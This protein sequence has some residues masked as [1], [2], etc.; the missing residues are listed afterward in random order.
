[1]NTAKHPKAPTR[2][3][4]VDVVRFRV[5]REPGQDVLSRPKVDK[6]EVAVELA[7]GLIADDAREHFWALYLDGQNRLVAAHEV[8]VGTLSA[9][10]VTPREIFGPALRLM[11]VAA[12]VL[13]HNHPSGDPEPSREDLSLTKQLVQAAKLFDLRIHDHVIIGMGPGAGFVSL[14]AREVL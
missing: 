13:A 7:R 10:L 5:V 14:A 4:A 6:P 9:T 2:N 11:G 8:G 12:I 1:M 3:Y